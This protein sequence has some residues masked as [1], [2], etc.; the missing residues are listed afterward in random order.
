MSVTEKPRFNPEKGFPYDIEK[1]EPFVLYGIALALIE[2]Q[3]M[4]ALRNWN[5]TVADKHHVMVVRHPE[6]YLNKILMRS[7]AHTAK[8]EKWGWRQHIRLLD[9]VVDALPERLHPFVPQMSRFKVEKAYR[10]TS[11]HLRDAYT[12]YRIA[13][14][15]GPDDELPEAV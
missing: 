12:E 4:V 11:Q 14:D 6:I 8:L 9:R 15:A 10:R 5:E 7:R 13:R 1:Q 3:Q 2:H